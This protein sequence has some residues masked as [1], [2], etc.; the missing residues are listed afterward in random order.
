M[1]T[2]IIPIT[3]RDVAWQHLSD[4]II[5]GKDILELLSSSMYVDPM[6]IYREY[7]QNAADSV[8]QARAEGILK[9]VES[10]CVWIVV[11]VPA[12]NVKITDNGTGIPYS[13]FAK[14]LTAF[15]AS[16]K[17]GGG[18]RG[19]RGVGRLA[20]MGYCQELIFRSRT[21]GEA[22]ISELRWDCRKLKAILRNSEGPNDLRDAVGQMVELRRIADGD[23][24]ERFF[25]VE[26]RGIIRHRND[27]LLSTTAINSYLAQVAPV[28][29]HKDFPF[30]GEILAH[31][32][33]NVRLGNL[34]ISIGESEIPVS[35]PHREALEVSAGAFD[36]FTDVELLHIGGLEGE[37]ACLGWVLHHGYTG[38]LPTSCNVRGLRV[39]S[40]NI[41]IGDER[42]FEEL[43]PETRFNGWTVGELHIIDP[44]IVPNGRRDHFEQNVHFHNL[45]THVA[46]LAR[47]ITRRCRT[48][49]VQRKWSRDFELREFAIRER[50]A[51]IKQGAISRNERTRIT[52]EIRAGLVFLEAVITKSV[53][54]AEVVA[55]LKK[56]KE[57]LDRDVSRM[58]NAPVRA[59]A[60]SDIPNS[61]RRVY[62]QVIGLIYE[63][64]ASQAN[65][66]LLVDKILSRLS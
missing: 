13:D 49:S 29:F 5:I 54:P 31:L 34:H 10:G 64:S 9:H 38:A 17:R 21:A 45:Q 20:G 22:K 44:R 36:P 27:Q 50:A 57:K 6:T 41:Q 65:A 1:S 28:P 7:V 52:D 26:M 15:G 43:F 56:R 16:K 40:G 42:M 8:D 46:P 19:F 23:A 25:E 2:A 12:R 62:E 55:D 59:S 63:C 48:S 30:K 32:G 11:D 33:S 4:D 47:E 18:A 53:F 61:K 14:R 39:R 51:I 37:T 60:L 58:L 66:K 24:P 3:L 35:R